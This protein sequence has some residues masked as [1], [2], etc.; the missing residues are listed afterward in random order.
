M[1]FNPIYLYVDGSCEDNRN[2]TSN[3]PAGWGFCV[4]D[5]D[6]GIGKG[7]GNLI[8]EESGKVETNSKLKNFLGADVGSNNT[9][10][11]SAI[12]YALRWL[13]LDHSNRPAIIRGDSKYAINIAKGVWKAK[14][15]RNLALRVQQLWSEVESIKSIKCEHVRAHIGH[16]WNERADHLAFRVMKGNKALPLQFWKPGNR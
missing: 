5:G 12:A 3:T 14:A 11:L 4:I 9:A 16:R 15:N 7:Q 13:L 10:E 1:D 6:N 8:Y 2:V